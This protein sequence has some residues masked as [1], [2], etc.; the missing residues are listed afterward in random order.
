MPDQEEDQQLIEVEV[1]QEGRL[2]ERERLPNPRAV[3]IDGVS[4]EMV[5]A[6]LK[7]LGFNGIDT[8]PRHDT[9]HVVCHRD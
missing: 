3:K 4:S 5:L 8:Y 7:S 1:V 2:A 9:F 6:D